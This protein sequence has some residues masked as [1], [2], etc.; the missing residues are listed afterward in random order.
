MERNKKKKIQMKKMIQMK[1]IKKMNP[2]VKMNRHLRD[3]NLNEKLS[4]HQLN[5]LTTKNLK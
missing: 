4:P 3:K 1:E 5:V 2:Q